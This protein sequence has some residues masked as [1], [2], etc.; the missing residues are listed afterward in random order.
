MP[1]AAGAPV[2]SGLPLDS[3]WLDCPLW[4]EESWHVVDESSSGRK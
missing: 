4:E 3:L 2:T 1:W